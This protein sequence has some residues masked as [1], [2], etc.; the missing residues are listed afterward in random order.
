MK[1]TSELPCFCL[2]AVSLWLSGT[3]F[4]ELLRCRLVGELL[5]GLLFGNLSVG[6]LLPV[7]KTLIILAGEVGVLGLVFEAGLGTNVY[8]VLKAGPRA[9]LVAFIGIIVPLVT[10]FGFIYGISQLKHIQELDSKASTGPRDLSENVIE[11]V[12][13]G[14]SLASTSI[15]IAVTMMKQQGILETALGTLITTAAMLDDVVSL[16][17]LGVVSSLGASS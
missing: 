2:F 17:L 3:L 14:A 13:S 8:R 9:A 11:A 12:A 5:V 15:A 16:I 10:G 4:E 1:F 6:T 7:D